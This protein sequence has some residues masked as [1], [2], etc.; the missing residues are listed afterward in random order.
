MEREQWTR[1]ALSLAA[2]V[3]SIAAVVLTAGAALGI[4]TFIEITPVYAI[5]ALTIFPWWGARRGGWRWA[6]FFPI[7][8]CFVM[9]MTGS[10]FFGFQT[11]FAIF[12]VTTVLLAGML[13]GDML[14]WVMVVL[15]TISSAFFGQ[16]LA[17]PG[18]PLSFLAPSFVVL[19][20]LTSAA[21]LQ[22]YYDTRLQK[23]MADL[24]T[25]KDALE[26]EFALRQQAE[27]DRQEKEA[28]YR[29]LADNTSDLVAEID[30]E[31][32][33]RFA[34]MSYTRVLGYQPEEL[35]GTNAF[36]L[37]HPE[38]LPATR[39]AAEQAA[40]SG[41]PTMVQV[42][43]RHANGSYL[44]FDVFGSPLYDD[45]G[46]FG[47]FV[48]SSRDV[49][50]QMQAETAI[51]E[52]EERFRAIIEA[53]PLGIHMY[54]LQEDGSLVFSGC[55]PAAVTILGY[56]QSHLIGL[57]IETAFP[58]LVGTEISERY[59]EAARSGLRW[60][61]EHYTYDDHKVSGAYEV[62]A[63][64]TSPGHMVAMFAD[65]T[66]RIQAAQ[67][68][69]LSEEK[70]ATA[71]RTSPDSININRL[72]DG[73]YL[74]INQGFT[75]IMGYER[76]D[77]I[78]K[79][80]LELNIWA[81]PA[82]RA[83]L[84]SGLRRNGEVH[85][86]EAKFQRKDGTVAFG[87][88]SARVIEIGGETCILSITRDMTER[89]KAE[90]DLR[91]AHAELEQAYAATLEGWVQALQM[92]EHETGEHSRRVV[93]LTMKIAEEMK[94][95]GEAQVHIQRGA[96]LHDIGKMGVPDEI[97]LKPGALT[98]DEW[99]IMRRHPEFAYSLLNEI[100]YLR[101]AIDIPF[102]HHERWDGSG[103][104]RGLRGRDIPVSARIF[105]VVD[106]YDALLN[107]RPYRPAWPEAEVLR[108]LA[109]QSG[110][111]FDPEI[112]ELFLRVK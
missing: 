44:F 95:D 85:N 84:V 99:V 53:S 14:R 3:V 5:L 72:S 66:E 90:F 46:K 105:A 55:N 100:A 101:P 106:V 92:R 7:G 24:A 68:L 17:P 75:E 51:Q 13:Q 112:V 40:S 83:R 8:L 89:H 98:P 87:L 41:T 65:I 107:R 67:A 16:R 28:Q 64:Q 60:D 37:V 38:D 35:L 33:F 56:D 77:V 20:G 70:F 102:C 22:W 80:S 32:I 36:S 23:I 104:P 2:R 103:Y 27:A 50:L 97:L 10:Y 15:G 21:L 52:S 76:Q 88:M 78:G 59:T 39:S 74:D 57:P 73:L 34:S 43:T 48:L 62:H 12:Y 61:G 42:R 19:F 47:G 86:L 4:F 31:G 69:M 79:T 30:A 110:K 49:T 109:E 93:E 25:G 111:Q 81:D 45:A 108:Y 26:T 94:I 82:D 58:I 63:F 18:E 54:T 6:R 96:L 1:D 71:F 9:A 11:G 29:R 91:Q